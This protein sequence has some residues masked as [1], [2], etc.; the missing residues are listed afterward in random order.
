MAQ[1]PCRPAKEMGLASPTLAWLGSGFVPRDPLVS[2]YLWLCLILDILKIC[3]DFGPYDDFLSSVVF[4]MVDQQ[5]SCNSLVISTYLLYHTWNVVMFT[6]NICILW[7]PT[8]TPIAVQDRIPRNYKKNQK[9]DLT[10]NRR[11][12]IDPKAYFK[13]LV[14]GHWD[15]ACRNQIRCRFLL[16][17][18]THWKIL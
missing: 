14:L 17:V 8:C 6:V 2:Y 12:V 5:N 11:S 13:C 9:N 4:E 10:L 16:C 15:S 18:G 3:N 1:T 7:P